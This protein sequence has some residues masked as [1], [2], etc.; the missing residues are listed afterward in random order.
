MRFL[1]I[2]FEE[3]PF[4][5]GGR[6]LFFFRAK[7]AIRR[8]GGPYNTVYTVQKWIVFSP[9]KFFLSP[10]P[11]W[12]NW[13]WREEEEKELINF[14]AL[15]LLPYVVQYSMQYKSGDF[16]VPEKKLVPIWYRIVLS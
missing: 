4:E 12:F 1:W 7:G 13:S 14:N 2:H 9:E 8:I 5:V 16:Y 10:P 11:T 15:Q 3:I 6:D